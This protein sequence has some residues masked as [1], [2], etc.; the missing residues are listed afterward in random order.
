MKYNF[1]NNG[2]VIEMINEITGAVVYHRLDG[3]TKPIDV[4]T[5]VLSPTE[6]LCVSNNCVIDNETPCD[7]GLLTNRSFC[8]LTNAGDI[9]Q[10]N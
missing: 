1:Y 9:M 8:I 3:S 2:T 7:N 5:L 6:I 4:A 10:H